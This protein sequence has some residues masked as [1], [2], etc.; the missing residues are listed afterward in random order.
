MSETERHG[1]RLADALYS[2]F[3][4]TENLKQYIPRQV[5]V[6]MGLIDLD[7]NVV[8]RGMAPGPWIEFCRRSS[9]PLVLI[10]TALDTG[11]GHKT[12]LITERL[13]RKADTYAL[14]VLVK[15]NEAND[16]IVRFRV[17]RIHT[18]RQL[19]PT[20]FDAEFKTYTPAEYATALAE[21]HTIA[22]KHLDN[23]P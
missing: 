13:A 2:Q 22:K 5:A 16:T 18:P 14:C 23:P 1:R 17:R 21:L 20:P 11:Q 8:Q 12:T 19:E 6:E 3:H 7:K 9:E 10:E 4:R 15:A